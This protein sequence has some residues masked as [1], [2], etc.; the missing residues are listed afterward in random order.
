M[1]AFL[2]P[3]MLWGLLLAAV[4]VIIHLL[5][6]RRY[7]TVRWAAMD[8]LRAAYRKN[9]RRLRFENL[10]LLLLRTALIILLA[11]ALARPFLTGGVASALSD[12]TTNY[13]IL[14]DNSYSMGLNEGVTSPFD[15]GVR[16]ALKIAGSMEREDS[17][18]LYLTN[19]NFGG[20]RPGVPRSVFRDSHDADKARSV[21]GRLRVSSA[22][23]RMVDALAIVA[24]R[25]D[26]KRPGKVLA[27]ITDLTRASW[28]ASGRIEVDAPA[29]GAAPGPEGLD[30]SERRKIQARSDAVCRTRL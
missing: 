23:S 13:T 7:R 2:H 27:V 30:A 5:N 10:L 20:A 22:R 16:E 21:L 19:D 8:F 14:L 29:A 12:R 25:M 26:A 4:P 28:Q 1:S 11:L 3:A 6:R 9:Q 15:R 18:S 24:D 17:V